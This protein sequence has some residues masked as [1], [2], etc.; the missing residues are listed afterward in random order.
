MSLV[1]PCQMDIA[2]TFL[3]ECHRRGRRP[4]VEDR[5]AAIHVCDK[6]RRV[7]FGAARLQHRTPGRE[8]AEPAIPRRFRIRRNDGN[9][10]LNDVGPI[11][12]FLGISFTYHKNNGGIIGEAGGPLLPVIGDQP[13][14]ANGIGVGPHRQADDVRIESVNDGPSLTARAAMRLF[15]GDPFAGFAFVGIA[16]IAI[17]S[18][19]SSRVG[20]QATFKIAFSGDCCQT[21]SQATAGRTTKYPIVTA[22]SQR[23]S[24][25][26]MLTMLIGLVHYRHRHHQRPE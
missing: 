21:N 5:R 16:K 14:F 12:D 7:G 10:M 19:R 11:V 4:R 2:D 23:M 1:F 22:T 9:A 6:R 8:K 25:T 20:S 3:R 18:R 26:A 24:S 15:D 17:Q 13:L